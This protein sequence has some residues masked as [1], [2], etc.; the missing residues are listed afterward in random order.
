MAAT[1]NLP[2]AGP[3]ALPQLTFAI[4][5]AEAVRYA[6][7]PTISFTLAVASDMPVRSLTLNAQIRIAPTRRRYDEGDEERLIELFGTRE[8]WGETVRAFLWAN[9][10][11]V[12]PPFAQETHATLSVPC[13]YDMQVAAAKYFSA[14]RDGDVPL[15]FLFSGTVFHLGDGGFLRA[16]QIPWESEAQFRLPVQ[17]W[18]DAMDNHFPNSAWLRVQSDVFD[19]LVAYKGRRLLPTWEATIDDLLERARP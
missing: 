2:S 19:R 16:A 13:T 5:G 9:V 4:H 18:R 6:A 12:V 14:L 3:E 8:R 15:E 11:V 7:A 10:T 1:T 17:L